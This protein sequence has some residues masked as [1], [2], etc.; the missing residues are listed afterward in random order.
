MAFIIITLFINDVFKGLLEL[1]ALKASKSSKARPT[2]L[3]LLPRLALALAALAPQRGISQAF[4][5]L[6]R[7]AVQQKQ[8]LLAEDTNAEKMGLSLRFC[9]K[10]AIIMTYNNDISKL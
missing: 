5:A 2:R 9:F 8:R 6:L 3:A 7:C 1:E 4:K 10:I